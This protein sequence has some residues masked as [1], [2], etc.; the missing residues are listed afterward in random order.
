MRAD[1]SIAGLVKQIS[2]CNYIIMA[3]AQ[4]LVYRGTLMIKEM[5]NIVW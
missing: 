1:I 3:D 4:E 2:V 5:K